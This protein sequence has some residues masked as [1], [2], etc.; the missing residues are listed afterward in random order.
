M[1]PYLSSINLDSHS[2]TGLRFLRAVRLMGVPDILQYLNILK[3]SSSIRLCQLAV[4]FISVSLTA[5]G[6]TH[7][8]SWNTISL[9]QFCM[10]YEHDLHRFARFLIHF[11]TNTTH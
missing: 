8:A 2:S 4:T 1:T 7:L 11:D 3:G 5:A 6:F 9:L 10:F